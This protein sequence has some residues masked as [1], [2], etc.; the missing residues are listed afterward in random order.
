MGGLAEAE[1]QLGGSET[2]PHTD[3]PTEDRRH[4]ETDGSETVAT[5]AQEVKSYNRAL[6]TI[7]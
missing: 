6:W 5:P 3:R 2:R 4:T 1:R 7:C